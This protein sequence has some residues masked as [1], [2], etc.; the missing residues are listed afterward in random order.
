MKNIATT[1]LAIIIAYNFGTYSQNTPLNASGELYIKIQNYPGN[2]YI[3]ANISLVGMG[4]SGYDGG[5]KIYS[6][7]YTDTYLGTKSIIG[8]SYNITPSSGQWAIEHIEKRYMSSSTSTW[9]GYGLYKITITDSRLQGGSFYFYIDYLDS[10]YPYGLNPDIYVYYDYNRPLNSPIHVSHGSPFYDVYPSIG[11]VIRVW[12][13]LFGQGNN[14]IGTDFYLH[15]NVPCDASLSEDE[16]FTH[17][18]VD[19]D[20]MV[21]SG[22]T[23]TVS[24]DVY[25]APSKLQTLGL[26]FN[27]STSLIIS[28]TLNVTG[29]ATNKVNFNFISPN[30]STQ[31]GIKLN[32]GS[33][34]VMYYS[35]PLITGNESSFNYTGIG[36]SN[37]SSPNFGNSQYSGNNNIHD[38][39][40]GVYSLTYSNPFLGQE[41][42]TIVG[43]NNIL[44]NNTFRNLQAE[45]NCTILAEHNWWGADPPDANKIAALTGSTIDYDPWLHQ[46]PSLKIVNQSTHPYVYNTNI[47]LSIKNNN[48]SIGYPAQISSNQTTSSFDPSWPIIL[49]YYMLEI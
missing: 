29:Y 23:F 7:V 33:S 6:N 42:P 30:S 13:D 38:N 34:A 1:I 45:D 19:G 3:N 16:L 14:P 21:N 44:A 32:S 43:G 41:I 37:S 28:G 12:A 27:S 11:Q 35:S 2:F 39:Y 26:D 46:P 47:Q 18:I 4:F 31:N 49:K 5:T 20:V 40:R 24:R 36:C 22:K 48:G 17:V 15:G 10:Q 25:P 9:I 8:G